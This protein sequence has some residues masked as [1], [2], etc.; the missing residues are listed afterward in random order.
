MAN[1][2]DLKLLSVGHSIQMAGAVYVGEGKAYLVFFPDEQL[3]MLNGKDTFLQAPGNKDLDSMLRL[4]VLSMNQEEWQVFLR[5]TDLLET[6][7]LA[8]AADGTIEKAIIRK[9]Q[10]QIEQ[11]VSWRVFKRDGYAC[12][13]CAN[14]DTPLTVDHLV[15]WE[16]GGP[17]TVENLVAAC[18][19]CNKTRGDLSYPAWLKH[20]Y[21]QKVS[22]NLPE[23]VQLANVRLIDTLDQIPRL[24]HKRSR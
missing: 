8:R 17:S 5:Q 13:Y 15:T 19:K 20:A 1:L 14:D 10:R 6:E 9:S 24:V 16:S 11:G 2:A 18:R 22:V 12:R 21:Y 4:E 7:V 23:A 3:E